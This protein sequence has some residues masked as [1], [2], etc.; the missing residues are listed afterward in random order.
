MQNDAPLPFRSEFP[1]FAQVFR[2]NAS[3]RARRKVWSPQFVS[4]FIAPQPCVVG[5]VATAQLGPCGFPAHCTFGP[6]A[7][8][9]TPP[10]TSEIRL[11]LRAPNVGRF[12]SHQ[13]QC[14]SHISRSPRPSAA[15]LAACVEFVP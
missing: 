2:S 4:R 10:L 11:M 12:V 9:T 7:N 1:S 14:R 3:S 8:R 13:V 5:D 6:P 15:A